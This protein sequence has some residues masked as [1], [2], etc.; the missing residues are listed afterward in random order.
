MS[1]HELVSYGIDALEKNPNTA[2]IGRIFNTIISYSNKGEFEWN[3]L[4]DILEDK[5]Y[6]Y[7]IVDIPGV[8]SSS[9]ELNFFN[10][11]IEISGER[12]IKNNTENVIK[13]EINDGK[14]CRELTIPLSITKKES[15]SYTTELGVLEIKI[16]KNNEKEN[17]FSI[18]I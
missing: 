3:P 15:I 1:L 6:I 2:I 17:K 11:K 9:I 12:I 8:I 10:N 7:I 4:V 18:K 13:N 5:N 16:D 14:F